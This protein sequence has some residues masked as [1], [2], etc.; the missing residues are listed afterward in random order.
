MDDTGNTRSIL[1]PD[2][3]QIQPLHPPIGGER[4]G[5]SFLCF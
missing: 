4:D 5:F 3:T 1:G 2:G